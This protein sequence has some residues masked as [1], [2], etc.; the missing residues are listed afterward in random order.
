MKKKRKHLSIKQI[1]GLLFLS[2]TI[3]VVIGYGLITLSNNALRTDAVAIEISRKAERLLASM[4]YTASRV[5][6]KDN[7]AKGDLKNFIDEYDDQLDILKNG[8]AITIQATEGKVNATTGENLLKLNELNKTWKDYKT[9]LQVILDEKVEIDTIIQPDATLEE[10]IF[11]EIASTP[12]VEKI[13]N[14]SVMRAY[15]NLVDMQKKLQQYN[16]ELTELYISDYIQSQFVIQFLLFIV[17]LFILAGLVFGYFYILRSFVKPLDK[18]AEVTEEISHGDFTQRFYY[19]RKDEIGTLSYHIN[20]LITGLKQTTEF[21]KSIGQFEFA[22]DYKAKGDKDM[23]SDALIDMRDNLVKVAEEDA[24]RNWANEGLAMFVDILRT[25]TDD[26]EDLS[27]RIVSHLVNYLKANQGG[28]F[29]LIKE[30]DQDAYLE[31]K[32]SF[33]YDQRKYVQKRIEVGQGLIGQA[34]L[35]K[36]TLHLDRVPEEY[37]EITSGLG[38]A[39]PKHLLIVPLMDNNEVY[40]ALEIASFNPFQTHEIEFVEN[41]SD[42]IASTLANVRT[43][44]NTQRLLEE[45]QQAA[46]QMQAQDEM[47]RQN[48]EELAATQEVMRESQK[49]LEKMKENLELQ[50]KE[51][52]VELQEKEAQL[53]E[54]LL[55][56]DLAPWKLDVDQQ[57][58]VGNKEFFRILRTN[59]EIE[60]G[61]II[62]MERFLNIFV[63]D[64]DREN[65]NAGIGEAIT[66][67]DDIF[68]DTLE[69]RIKQIGGEVRNVALSIKRIVE[70]GTDRTK[71]LYGTIQ[72]ITRQ[73]NIEAK[74]RQQNDLLEK[75]QIEQQK[76]VAMVENATDFVMMVNMKHQVIYANRVGQEVFGVTEYDD[77]KIY[78]KTFFPESEW[79]K[80]DNEVLPEVMKYGFWEGELRIMNLKSKQIAYMT[81]NIVGI[82]DSKSNY[83]AIALI[84]RDITEQ[85]RIQRERETANLRMK[86]ILEST[87]DEIITVDTDFH[88]LAFNEQWSDFMQK[89]TGTTPQIGMH[90][91]NDFDYKTRP[92]LPEKLMEGWQ[93]AFEGGA[94]SEVEHYEI[95][96]IEK[97]KSGGKEKEREIL[98]EEFY[99]RRYYNPVKSK[100]GHTMGAVLFTKDITDQKLAEQTIVRSE[101]RLQA[102]TNSTTEGIVIH[103]KGYIK[104]VNKAFC[105]ITGYTYDELIGKYMFN[106]LDTESK[107]VAIINMQLGYDKS[108]DAV[109]LNKE[110]SEIPVEIQGRVV[111]FEEQRIRVFA[112]RNLS[113]QREAQ[114]KLQASKDMLQKIIDTLPQSVFWKDTDSVFL[115]CNKKFLQTVG[116]E[117]VED[118]VG[119]TDY[120]LFNEQ[121]A[122]FYVATDKKIMETNMPEL[123]V[124]QSQIQANGRQAWLRVSKVPFHDSEGEV[125]GL[126]GTYQDITDQK[127]NE[128]TII[129]SKERLRKQIETLTSLGSLKL[130]DFNLQSFASRAT[131]SI[132]STLNIARVSIWEY[133]YETLRCIDVYDAHQEKHEEGTVLK[134]E[135]YPSFF[136]ALH[137]EPVIL[138]EFAQVDPRTKELTPQYLAAASVTSL[139]TYPVRVGGKL[140]GMISC[141][142]VRTPR[143]WTLEE[144]SFVTSM[145]DLLTIKIEEIEKVRME[146]SLKRNNL[147]T[148]QIIDKSHDSIVSLDN[149]HR[150]LNFNSKMQKTI[151]HAFDTDLKVGND[152][153]KIFEDTEDYDKMITAWER[154]MEQ[155][156]HFEEEE[157]YGSGKY[158][159]KVRVLFEP[160]MS[161][162]QM[163]GAAIYIRKP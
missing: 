159:S 111:R 155:K 47:M 8:R 139:L 81:G 18:M 10:S 149:N 123:D 15:G 60:G 4:A 152:W 53:S 11:A 23:L 70:E 108:Y 116:L 37:I 93:K 54:A 154:L 82:K 119:K 106:F 84:L 143:E 126:I 145:L 77:K 78:L 147:I 26:L 135:D 117:Q 86:S 16:A 134:E 146:E 6:E 76:F 85:H 57:Q 62:P 58:M 161:D 59:N 151:S 160:L 1:I 13:K 63:Y 137:E 131:E 150:I 51:R 112:I 36:D 3:L 33:A 21:A 97:Y 20:R 45:S 80:F 27:Y 140:K 133:E 99:F 153:M 158:R 38:D 138:S 44:Q 101:Q 124:L 113:E 110:K 96:E 91:F 98:L 67:Y 90:L 142:H 87:E 64:A 118:I 129:E 104:D 92:E 103:D 122:E 66:S 30:E 52:T 162:D 39:T 9:N 88:I 102:I 156:K 105:Q 56:A 107:A 32:A 28:L 12:T 141:E 34:V 49:E 22:F 7:E 25:R 148:E 94:H 41:L 95:T 136:N 31:M 109:L 125:V 19:E 121:E 128:E 115:G 61:F 48:M 163:I 83:S 127:K 5:V 100:E 73:K 55:L 79:V 130:Q 72:D 35:E 71:F 40:G 74:I 132:S 2:L 144:Q 43:S 68:E 120:D 65:V 75:Q 69:F 157:E 50:V 42:N 46:E 114:Q 17:I 29:V 24:R 14:P 89:E